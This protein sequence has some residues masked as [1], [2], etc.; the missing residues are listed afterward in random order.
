MV[1]YFSLNLMIVLSNYANVLPTFAKLNTPDGEQRELSSSCL[2]RRQNYT[3]MI[4]T[5]CAD[6]SFMT[7]HVQ[8]FAAWPRV[9]LGK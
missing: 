1:Q 2:A 4:V 5:A 3:Q 8:V 9:L 6:N 7:F